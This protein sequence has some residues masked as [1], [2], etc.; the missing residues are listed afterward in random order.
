LFLLGTR[1]LKKSEAFYVIDGHVST[2]SAIQQ[3][4][5]Q[6]LRHFA[7]FEPDVDTK[8]YTLSLFLGRRSRGLQ[9][10]AQAAV[11]S[12]FGIDQ[13]LE[14]AAFSCPVPQHEL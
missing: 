8:W 1:W 11:G 2:F 6:F 7:T 10:V 13:K 14:P 12:A 3:D 4:H 9:Q 5:S